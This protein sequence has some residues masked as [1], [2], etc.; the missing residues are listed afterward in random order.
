MEKAIIL[1]AEECTGCRVCELACSITKQGE[2]NPKKSYIRVLANKDF[3]VYL[4][5]LKT[6]C[7][8]CGKCVEL[9]PG[10]ALKIS[11][12]G[13]AAIMMRKSKIGSFPIPLVS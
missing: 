11:E 10:Q 4:P 13:E 6:E 3:G 8:F 12:L 5:V 7:D 1:N 9:C 2:F